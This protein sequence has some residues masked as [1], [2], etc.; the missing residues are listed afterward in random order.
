MFFCNYRLICDDFKDVYGT[1]T[2]L[3]SE[4]DH[5]FFISTYFVKF[6]KKT[7]KEIILFFSIFFEQKLSAKS[8]KNKLHKNESILSVFF[9]WKFIAKKLLMNY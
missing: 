6:F 2:F 1:V 3:I 8:I 9:F 4:T 5:F 7:F